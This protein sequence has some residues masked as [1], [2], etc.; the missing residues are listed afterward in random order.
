MKRVISRLPSVVLLCGL[1]LVGQEVVGN[2]TEDFNVL[3]V[4]HEELQRSFDVLQEQEQPPYYIS[5]EITQDET[6]NI[7][8]SYGEIGFVSDTSFRVLDI[9]LRVGSYELDNTH[10]GSFGGGSTSISIESPRAIRNTLWYATNTRYRNAVTTLSNV[11]SA[12]QSRVE[13]VDKSGDFARAPTEEHR[14]EIVGL[15]ANQELFEAKVQRYGLPFKR[16]EHIISNSVSI[17][18]DVETRWFVN[19]DGTKIQV[20][21]PYY[22]I[23]IS[24][25]SKAEDGMILPRYVT[26]AAS[27]VEGLPEDATI[28]QD[29]ENLI[30]NLDEMREAPLVDPYTGPAI[31]SGRASGVFFHEILGHRLEGHRQ[32]AEHEGQTFKAKLGEHVLPKNFSVS[33]DPNLRTFGSTELIGSYKFDNQGVRAQRVVVVED[34]ILMGFLMSRLPMKG[35]LSSNGHGRKNYGLPVVARQSNMFVEVEDPYS[36]EELQEMLL[37]RVREQGKEFGLYFDDIQGGFTITQRTLPNAFTVNPIVVYRLYTDG[38]KELVRGVNLIG[39]PLTTFSR[40]EAGASDYGI[41]NGMCGAE[42]GQI[43]VSAVAPSILVSQIEVQKATSS[44]GRPPIL[45]NPVESHSEA[46]FHVPHIHP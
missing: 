46:S 21:E 14:D 6:L 12:M 45:P 17:G 44:R 7:S 10:F 38:H 29:I 41:F 13:E 33:F 16:A 35:F 20:S 40:V 1:F 28:L 19:T 25:S 31:L 27:T 11:K 37:E 22:R 30:E 8:G 18:G 3:D 34:G 4:M 32:K 24:A 9:D 2:Q 15:Q 26:Y 36:P 23:V 5:Y 42:S 39:T 43:P